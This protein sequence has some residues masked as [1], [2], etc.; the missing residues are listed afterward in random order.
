MQQGMPRTQQVAPATQ[1]TPAASAEP[2]VAA[3][4]AADSALM[5]LALIETSGLS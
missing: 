4:A 5:N 2:D 3:S 1:Q